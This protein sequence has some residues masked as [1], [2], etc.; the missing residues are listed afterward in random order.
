MQQRG[1]TNL[2]EPCDDHPCA[3]DAGGRLRLNERI[4]VPAKA[5]YHRL[6]K[7][8]LMRSPRTPGGTRLHGPTQAAKLLNIQLQRV[9][10][11]GHM[12]AH[13]NATDCGWR[14]PSRGAS[15]DAAAHRAVSRR[16][17]SSS[18]WSMASSVAMSYQPVISAPRLRVMGRYRP[19]RTGASGCMQGWGLSGGWASPAV[20]SDSAY[21]QHAGGQHSGLACYGHQN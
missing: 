18:C 16:P 8:E 21:Q 12:A 7:C 13:H 3:G 4:Q 20:R 9:R 2:A 14:S 15:K 10:A 1:G 5:P 6:G 11:L 19:Q 17:A